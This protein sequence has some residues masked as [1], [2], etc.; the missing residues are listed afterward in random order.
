MNIGKRCGKPIKENGRCRFHLRKCEPIEE[1]KEEEVK[2]ELV[3]IE[4]DN[5]EPIEVWSV[6]NINEDELVNILENLEI[7]DINVEQ[8]HLLETEIN[9]CFK[10]GKH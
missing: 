2:E 7:S 6:E 8:L 5:P 4:E 9:N 1:K 3:N 10:S